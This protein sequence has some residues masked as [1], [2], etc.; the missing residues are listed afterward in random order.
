MEPRRRSSAKPVLFIDHGKALPRLRL[1]Y[2]SLPFTHPFRFNSSVDIAANLEAI[3]ERVTAAAG[4][5]GRDPST[6]RLMAV[7]KTQPVAAIR[8]AVEAGQ[9]LFGENKI[10]EARLKI[11]ECPPQANFHFIGHLQSN[12]A[13]DAVRLFSM[14]QGVDS[15]K[16]AEELD[17][18]ADQQARILPVLIEVNVAGEA[19]KFGYSPTDLL[20]DLDRLVELPRLEIHGLMTIPPFSTDPERSRPF[21]RKL[22]DLRQSC[23]DRLGVPLTEL[24]MGMSGDFEA[25]IEE[26]STMVRVGTA[27][28]GQRRSANLRPSKET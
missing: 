2:N 10:Q 14:I 21:F 3:R 27:I 20:A 1:G 25:A 17:K 7:S 22:V 11:P 28:F 24:S 13:R 15:L 9:I 23:E 19:S 6:I 8:A 4:R 12:K 16:L 18:H 26:G 5:A